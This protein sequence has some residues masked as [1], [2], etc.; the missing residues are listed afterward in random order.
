ML[1][2]EG[3]FRG[4]VPATPHPPLINY[5]PPTTPNKTNY[6]LP[7]VPEVLEDDDVMNE[8]LRGGDETPRAAKALQV[9]GDQVRQSEY[10]ARHAVGP[11]P[12]ASGWSDNPCVPNAINFRAQFLDSD[13]YLR[14]GLA[15]I[16]ANT[17]SGF[18]S[19]SCK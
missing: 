9:Y 11:P 14:A 15:E 17:A 19:R 13:I 1:H 3:T 12:S 18:R 5:L 7:T 8:A 10:D 16:R 2:L 6:E 4:H